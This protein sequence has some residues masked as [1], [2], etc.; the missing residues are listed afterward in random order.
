MFLYCASKTSS[1]F[2]FACRARADFCNVLQR[3]GKNCRPER[4]RR[5]ARSKTA[6]QNWAFRVEK[7]NVLSRFKKGD[8]R[9]RFFQ[10]AAGLRASARAIALRKRRHGDDGNPRANPGA[11]LRG[12]AK[13][14]TTDFQLSVRERKTR[15]AQNP[16]D[17]AGRKNNHRRSGRGSRHDFAGGA[18]S[19]DVH[20]HAAK[21]RYG[22]R[23][24]YGRYFRGRDGDDDPKTADAEPILASVEF[25]QRR[26]LLGRTSR[27]KCAAQGDAKDFSQCGR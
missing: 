20:G 6:K 8:T 11:E 3:A 13:S 15:S 16:G 2:R 1:A 21:A 14:R 18:S 24:V 10:R 25:Y 12:R 23:T 17:Q 5:K 26:H 7:G 22:A 9:S 27:T 4:A 19:A